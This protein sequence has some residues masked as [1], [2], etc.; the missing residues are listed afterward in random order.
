MIFVNSDLKSFISGAYNGKNFRLPF[1]EKTYNVL[2]ELQKKSENV[3]DPRKFADIVADFAHEVENFNYDA[4]L[5]TLT[6]GIVFSNKTGKYHLVIDNQVYDT[7]NVPDTLVI[8]IKNNMDSN[9]D[10]TPI[11]NLCLRFML[12]I[13]PTQERFEMLA[14]Y[15]TQTFT[16]EKEMERL[17]NEKGLSEEVAFE[18]AT[19]PDLQITQ[20]GY[21]KTSKVV[22]EITTKWT[23]V[24]DTDGNP[25]KDEFGDIIREEVNIYKTSYKIDEETAEV[26]EEI[27][28][29]EF[30]EDRKFTPAIYK[31]GDLFYSG[32]EKGYK[33]QIGK[34]AW[35]ESWDLVD[36]TDEIK[37]QRGLHTGGLSYIQGY[38]TGNRV[39]LDVFVCPSMI[40]KFTDEGLGEL[41]AK[42]FFI[43]GSAML[44][45]NLRSMYHTSTY[46][47]ILR[48]ELVKELKAK[49][50]NVLQDIEAFK[51]SHNR[52]TAIIS[53]VI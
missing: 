3:N 45:T 15:V 14:A 13:N 17:M 22:D 16:D 27:T 51:N 25:L 5:I 38:L 43:Y 24:L 28:Y 46:T 30:L 42:E 26:T 40:A 18:L 47:N 33:Y 41:T 35:L 8:I 48:E 1:D 53:K 19:Y 9:I 21:L 20:E 34:R 2:K 12:N 49:Y 44:G 50:E 32:D 37:H 29:P 36:T 52:A 31:S 6:D 39:L 11:I 7:L 4:K 23:I 10:S